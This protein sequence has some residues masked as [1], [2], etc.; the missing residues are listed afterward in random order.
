MKTNLRIVT[1]LMKSRREDSL[2]GFIRMR[3][4]SFNFQTVNLLLSQRYAQNLR[5]MLILHINKLLKS[6]RLSQIQTWP[7][8]YLRGLKTKRF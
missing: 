2:R 6:N 8:V 3:P 4:I 7:L 5:K 1:K